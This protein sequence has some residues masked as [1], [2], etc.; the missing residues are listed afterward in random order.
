M[1]I[2]EKNGNLEI[3][4]LQPRQGM[5]TVGV[6]A[7]TTLFVGQRD[8]ELVEGTAYIFHPKCGPFGYQAK[9]QFLEGQRLL[10]LEGMSPRLNRGCEVERELPEVLRFERPSM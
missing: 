8:G 10:H 4:Y 9:G 6:R 3:A 2:S 7:N 1:S 5:L